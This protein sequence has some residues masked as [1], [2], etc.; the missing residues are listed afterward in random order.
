MKETM[1]FS[2]G[3]LKIEFENPFSNENNEIE[4]ALKLI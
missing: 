4:E 2:C 3:Q 1:L